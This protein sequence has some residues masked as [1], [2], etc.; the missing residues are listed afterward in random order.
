MT[1]SRAELH[2]VLRPLCLTLSSVGP[3]QVLMRVANLFFLEM[4][5]GSV[6]DVL[7]VPVFYFMN[8]PK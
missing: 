8:L 1:V 7:T 5:L 2:S 6:E 3:L 4:C